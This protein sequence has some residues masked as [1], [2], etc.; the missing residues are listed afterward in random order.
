[1]EMLIATLTKEQ[2]D[3]VEAVDGA[4]SS[5]DVVPSCTTSAKWPEKDILADDKRCASTPSRTAEKNQ[6]M[7][8]TDGEW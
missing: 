2:H 6:P 3:D 4:S 1:M 7:I 5:S 8:S